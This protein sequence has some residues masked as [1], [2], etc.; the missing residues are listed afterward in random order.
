MLR[1][2]SMEKRRRTLGDDCMYRRFKVIAIAYGCGLA[3]L[4]SN[5]S[6]AED[7][8]QWRGPNRDGVVEGVVLP[9]QL[10]ESLRAVWSVEVGEDHSA[11]VVVGCKAVVFVRQEENEVEV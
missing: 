10:P 1:R 9:N 3:M 4:A 8:P 6:Q 5:L 7:W 2:R 11:P